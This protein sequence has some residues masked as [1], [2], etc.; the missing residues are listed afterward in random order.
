MKK[1]FETPLD[2]IIRVTKEL[3]TIKL[4]SKCGNYESLIYNGQDALVKSFAGKFG[5]NLT[6]VKHLHKETIDII[7]DDVKE[8][9]S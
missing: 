5:Y 4:S 3:G 1:S 6:D 2:F 7:Y 9:F 8:D